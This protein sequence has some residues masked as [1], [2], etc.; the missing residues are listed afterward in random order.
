[1]KKHRLKEQNKTAAL[2]YRQKKRQEQNKFLDECSEIEE[3][4]RQLKV[5][6]EELQKE[7][8]YLKSLFA[9]I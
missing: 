1:E 8:N 9:E 7:I 4:N 5:R 2:K 3:K 6:A